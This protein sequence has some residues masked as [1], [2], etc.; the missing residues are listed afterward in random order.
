MSSA[1]TAT[2][3]GAAGVTPATPR[4]FDG[5]LPDAWALARAEREPVFV[6]IKPYCD[7]RGWSY[8]NQM[9][10]VMSAEG[11]IN[12][13]LQYPG[14]IKAWHRHQHQTDFWMCLHGHLKV[15]V[16]RQEDHRAW[17]IVTG[18]MR[19]GVVVIPP[20]LWHGAATVGER[21]AGLLYYVTKA[22]NPASPDEE[23]RAHDSVAGFPWAPQHR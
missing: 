12:F 4:A 8:M 18:Q 13:S 22:F 7:D 17:T 19:P 9:Q 14:V 16:Y 5:P 6:P 3:P 23:R 10:G 21:P 2:S 1:A 15:G 20:P 11:Q